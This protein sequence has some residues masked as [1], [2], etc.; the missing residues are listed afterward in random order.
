MVSILE[1]L[2]IKQKKNLSKREQEEL[3]EKSR[4]PEQRRI[5]HRIRYESICNSLKISIPEWKK[6]IEDKDIIEIPFTEFTTKMGPN[7]EKWHP[8]S[9]YWD[10]KRCLLKDGI[11]L[12][13]IKKDHEKF[14]AM[15]TMKPEYVEVIGTHPPQELIRF[16][17]KS[18]LAQKKLSKYI[19]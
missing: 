19:K 4:T 7:T 6:E 2:G 18:E 10:A 1:A 12:T 15:V 16:P 9:V 5:A 11:L 3:K 17:T 13:S 14:A 8:T